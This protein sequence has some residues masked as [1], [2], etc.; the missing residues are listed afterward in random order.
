MVLWGGLSSQ[1]FDDRFA[2][3]VAEKMPAFSPSEIATH[4]AW[5]ENL[6]VLEERRRRQ[7]SDWK[8]RKEVCD[9]GW[10]S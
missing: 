2:A 5:Y 9:C 3:K 4:E 1:D 8:R 10:G 7:I 6:V